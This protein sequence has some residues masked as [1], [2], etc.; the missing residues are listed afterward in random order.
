MI[1]KIE[2]LNVGKTDEQEI[3]LWAEVL[4][5]RNKLLSNSDWT[6]VSD[7]GLTPECAE[8]W[9]NWRKNLKAIN[10]INFGDREVAEQV[11]NR[12]GRRI[13]FNVYLAVNDEPDASR[14]VS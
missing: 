7:S 14:Y 12:L 5:H 11:I 2:N 10:R 3:Q 9:R 1:Q 13:P 6:Q 4:S 8:Q